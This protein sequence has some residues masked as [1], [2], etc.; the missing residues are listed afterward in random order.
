VRRA[1]APEA[2]L[3]LLR[4]NLRRGRGGSLLLA[5]RGLDVA[6]TAAAAATATASTTTIAT[7]VATAVTTM[8]A[9]MA[10]TT[11]MAATMT[12]TTTAAP[13]AIA[14]ATGVAAATTQASEDKGRSLLLTAHQG[15]PN[16]REKH[17]ESKNNDTVHPQILQLL[18]G[19]V[20]GKYHVAVE[21]GSHAAADGSAPQCDRSLQA[22][23]TPQPGAVPVVK[24]YGLQRM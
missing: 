23:I 12:T 10:A 20:S 11:T 1:S 18:T 7:A 6:A 5:N 3:T 15:N 19:T 17:R 8:V 16:Q 14:A 13:A 21:K 4:G 2:Q 22:A 9:S 24:I